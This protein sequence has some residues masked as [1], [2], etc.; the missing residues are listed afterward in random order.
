MLSEILLNK[1]KVFIRS[2]TIEFNSEEAREFKSY[3][4]QKYRD[5]VNMSCGLCVASCIKKIIR[6]EN[7]QA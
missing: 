7:I 3:Y 5:N 1:I 6:D 2:H 4:Q